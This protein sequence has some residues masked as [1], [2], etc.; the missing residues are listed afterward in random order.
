L[1]VFDAYLAHCAA[2]LAKFDL[3]YATLASYR[4]VI[5][6]TW[7]PAIGHGASIK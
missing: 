7:R 2:R 1:D 5:D 6:A 4:R 3:A